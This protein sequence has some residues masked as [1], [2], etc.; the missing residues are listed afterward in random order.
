MNRFAVFAEA[1]E[2]PA[3]AAPVKQQAPQK[4]ATKKVVVKKPK[5]AEP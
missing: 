2:Q 5:T 3:G 4:E 1:E